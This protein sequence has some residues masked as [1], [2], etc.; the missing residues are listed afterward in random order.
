[1]DPCNGS[2]PHRPPIP[3]LPFNLDRAKREIL[4]PANF[5]AL[6]DPTSA[7][8][9]TEATKL[10]RGRGGKKPHPTEV[11]RWASHGWKTAL[12]GDD[13][14]VGTWTLRF[15]M[16]RLGRELVTLPAWVAWFERMRLRFSGPAQSPAAGA[17]TK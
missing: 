6:D 2:A 12:R 15:P 14:T 11:R 17:P 3:G 4:P 16:Q 8:T 1:M 5:P 13:G 7:I 9:I 10:M